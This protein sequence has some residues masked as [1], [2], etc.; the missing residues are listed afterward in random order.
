MNLVKPKSPNLHLSC[1]HYSV[2]LFFKKLH[3]FADKTVSRTTE[4]LK[5]IEALEE[6]GQDGTLPF[7]TNTFEEVGCLMSTA[8]DFE[9]CDCLYTSKFY[10]HL[11]TN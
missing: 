7:L 6:G 9:I 10:F 11:T 4:V 1:H 8:N 5:Y 2:S 3:F